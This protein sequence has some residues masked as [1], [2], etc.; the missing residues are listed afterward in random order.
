LE[1]FRLKHPKDSVEEFQ[2]W[3]N[4]GELIVLGQE[5]LDFKPLEYEIKN[6]Q[7]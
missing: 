6:Q 5:S 4:L 1:Q 2:V 3:K 7:K